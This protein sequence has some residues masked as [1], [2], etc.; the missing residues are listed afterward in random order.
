[1]NVYNVKSSKEK[2]NIQITK[3]GNECTVYHYSNELG[4][5]LMTG[6]E[7]FQGI[8]LVYNDVHISHCTNIEYDS[9]QIESV[10]EINHCR[11]GRIECI[12][13]NKFFYLTPGDMSIHR[14]SM[15][16]NSSTFPSCHY[17]GVSVV[18][19]IREAPDTLAE[20]L[21]EVNVSPKELLDRICGEKEFFITRSN[22]HL[23]H[24]F[25]E[26][27]HIPEKVKKG[28]FRIKVLE[29]LLF[30][31][32]Y[33]QKKT[34][35]HYYTSSQVKLA[36]AVCSYLTERMSERIT[37]D[38]LAE[39]FHVSPTYIKKC[40][41]GVYGETVHGYI[42][43]QKMNSASKMLQTTDKTILEIA[44]LHGYENGSKFAKAFQSVFEKSPK[45]YRR[46]C[47][48]NNK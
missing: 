13:G 41:Q 43:T 7:V 42:R 45:Q 16:S 1:M 33:E 24:I 38:M 40:F 23:E 14:K 9:R 36:K 18:I 31:S 46:D 22:E 20:I 19:D 25:S 26:L 17:H 34:A 28:Y 29:I 27:Y 5:V 15:A 37:I 4:E 30:L 3:K 6:Y 12:A 21:Q 39:E 44:N 32:V 47:L 8:Q 2:Y 48:E 11:E 10:Y 35:S